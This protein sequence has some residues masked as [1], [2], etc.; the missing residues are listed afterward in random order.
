MDADMVTGWTIMLLFTSNS[1][2]F[3]TQILTPEKNHSGENYTRLA[4]DVGL[5]HQITL[6]TSQNIYLWQET[7]T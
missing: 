1:H 2:G 7:I 5:I 3:T 6:S 4:F